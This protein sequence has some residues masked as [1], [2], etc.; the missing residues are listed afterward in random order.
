MSVAR[1]Y[2]LSAVLAP[3]MLL[4]LATASSAETILTESFEN[5][6]VGSIDAQGQTWKTSNGG[7]R[8]TTAM[9]YSGSKALRVD[10]GINWWTNSATWWDDLGLHG[11]LLNLSW[12]TYPT[13]TGGS[14][15]WRR[16]NVFG[17]D[18]TLIAEIAPHEKGSSST[19]DCMSNGSWT[20]TMAFVPSN[21]WT[22][23]QM[24]LDLSSDRYRFKA[25]EGGWS[26]WFATGNDETYLRRIEF[27]A[28]K[29]GYDYYVDDLAI[30]VV[31]EPSALLL[32]T[33]GLAFGLTLW[34]RRRNR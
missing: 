31:P 20:E 4:L 13:T 17:W 3:A 34:R 7:G 33:L 5:Y 19:I 28:D 10:E 15:T 9:A 29:N 26:S 16:V 21:Q 27:C 32:A 14:S 2:L 25:G 11:G 1:T 24:E 22:E 12:H 6:P 30:T 18:G 23:V 8:V